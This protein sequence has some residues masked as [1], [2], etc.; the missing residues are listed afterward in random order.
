MFS[1][2]TITPFVA[3][4]SIITL[5]C[6]ST[7]ICCNGTPVYFSRLCLN[8]RGFKSIN[9]AMCG[10]ECDAFSKSDQSKSLLWRNPR[11]LKTTLVRHLDRMAILAQLH[12]HFLGDTTANSL[13]TCMHEEKVRCHLN[14]SQKKKNLH[15]LNRCP[16]LQV[17]VEMVRTVTLP[18]EKK[19]NKFQWIL[20]DVPYNDQDIC[21]SRQKKVSKS[22]NNVQKLGIPGPVV[23]FTKNKVWLIEMEI[24]L[25]KRMWSCV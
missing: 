10:Q 16:F 3:Q 2:L 25:M 12:A 1:L 17:R 11:L 4:I 15:R 19:T 13:I 7:E 20:R 23:L 21:T 9:R 6:H 14:P 24:F 5:C 18:R 8:Y 22:N